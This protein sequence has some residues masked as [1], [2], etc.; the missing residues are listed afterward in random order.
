NFK[1]EAV[2]SAVLIAQMC[3][4]LR[5]N[6]CLYIRRTVLFAFRIFDDRDTPGR[7]FV[8]EILYGQGF[9]GL[10]P[11]AAR[12]LAAN[13]LLNEVEP[14]TEQHDASVAPAPCQLRELLII[15]AAVFLTRDHCLCRCVFDPEKEADIAVCSVR[16]QFISVSCPNI[17]R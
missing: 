12:V 7:D 15:G 14:R 4:T 9:R 10:V 2:I 5:R 13:D 6:T 3:A 17:E 1:Q 16:M 11:I 8:L